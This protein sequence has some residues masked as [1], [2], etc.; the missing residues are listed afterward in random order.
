MMKVE[1]AS[2]GAAV[3]EELQTSRTYRL[4]LDNGRIA[5]MIDSLDAVE[6]AVYK[7]L[8]TDRFAHF[9]YSD[10]YGMEKQ[11]GQ[12]IVHDLERL[13]T[14]ALLADDR[15]TGVEQFR[16]K[17]SGDEARVSFRVRSVFGSLSVSYGRKPE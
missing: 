5:G 14:E 7:I 6:Q 2:L 9:I 8:D 13:V 3:E 1:G 17:A 15:I 4:D 10:N 16:M 11:L 12:R